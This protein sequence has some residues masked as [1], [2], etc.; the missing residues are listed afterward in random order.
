MSRLAQKLGYD[1]VGY[2]INEFSLF[3]A[4]ILSLPLKNIRYINKDFTTLTQ[5]FDVVSAT[6]FLSVVE[7]KS[8]SLDVLIALLKDEDSTLVILEPSE[9]MTVTN[10]HTLIN[11]FKSWWFY[12]G[13]LLWAKAR[14]RK[15]ISNS[16]F[17]NLDNVNIYHE[18]DLNDM[19]K[20]TYIKKV[21]S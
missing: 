20:I 9:C 21:N 14:E 1:V 3:V 18:Y 17:D 19:I 2:D 16:V 8:G 7:D 15:S 12:K 5:K 13:L 11:D 6:S 4:K 10:V